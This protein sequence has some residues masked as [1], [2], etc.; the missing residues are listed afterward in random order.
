M[1]SELADGVYALPVL[2]ERTCQLL[3]AELAAVRASGLPL[4]RPNSMN[5]DGVLLDEMGAHPPHQGAEARGET[6]T[7]ARVVAGLSAALIA[8]LVSSGSANSW[9]MTAT[10]RLMR[11]RWY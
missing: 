5:T 4:G 2:S 1:D 3:C 6:L 11:R 9:R 7:R 10:R 8:P